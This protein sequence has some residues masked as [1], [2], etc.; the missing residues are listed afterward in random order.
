MVQP[1][2]KERKK[3]FHLKI[4]F[5]KRISF[6]KRFFKKVKMTSGSYLYFSP[7]NQKSEVV[8]ILQGKTKGE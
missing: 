2:K 8:L 4:T 3:E 5:K 6:K 7:K 1:K